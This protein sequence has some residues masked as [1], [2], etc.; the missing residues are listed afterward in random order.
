MHQDDSDTDKNHL[1]KKQAHEY[2]SETSIHGLKYI[3]ERE[4]TPFERRVFIYHMKLCSCNQRPHSYKKA[5][6]SC[7]I[8]WIVLC[9]LSLCLGAYMIWGLVEKFDTNPII[10]S[11]EETNYPVYKVQF[12]AV[13]ICSNNRISK[14]NLEKAIMKPP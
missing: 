12:P 14:K 7:R 11:I 6:S 4:R 5:F 9:I 2:A 8:L 1:L 13:T 10:T 3:G